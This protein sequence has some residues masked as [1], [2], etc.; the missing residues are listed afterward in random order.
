MIASF[1]MLTRKRL[2]KLLDP[3]FRKSVLASMRPDRMAALRIP[4]FARYMT[5]SCI[6]NRDASKE[7]DK[8]YGYGFSPIQCVGA[9]TS[10][11]EVL[12]R[13]FEFGSVNHFLRLKDGDSAAEVVAAILVEWAKEDRRIACFDVDRIDA[14]FAKIEAEYLAAEKAKAEA[15][16]KSKAAQAAE[17]NAE[18][19]PEARPENAGKA[20][21]T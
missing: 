21:E 20:A 19:A 7:N 15:E 14:E 17:T 12:M 3:A 8:D 18:T 13:F 16:A 4:Q 9:V 11:G 2:T 6:V 1:N 10:D 5:D